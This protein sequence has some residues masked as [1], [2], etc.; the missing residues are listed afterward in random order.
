M[1]SPE[2]TAHI[3]PTRMA[4]RRV[5]AG[6]LAAGVFVFNT[7]FALIGGWL[8]SG[9][10]SWIT[11]LRLGLWGWAGALFLASALLSVPVVGAMLYKLLHPPASLDNPA[12]GHL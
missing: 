3:L 8:L 12:R 10:A 5:M 9:P 7:L 1:N 6:R 2:E 11:G 4:R